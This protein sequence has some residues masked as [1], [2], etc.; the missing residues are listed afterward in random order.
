MTKEVNNCPPALLTRLW[1]FGHAC[2]PF[3]PTLQP[4]EGERI[5]DELVKQRWFSATPRATD[6]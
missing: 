4:C 6:P 1:V 5:F 2:S 3:A